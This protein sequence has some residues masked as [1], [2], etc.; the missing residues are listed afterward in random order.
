MASDEGL[1]FSPALGEG[2]GPLGAGMWL[3]GPAVLS[4]LL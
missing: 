4:Y 1:P 3:R 2:R